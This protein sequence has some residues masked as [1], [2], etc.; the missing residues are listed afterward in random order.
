MTRLFVRWKDA[1]LKDN[2][3]HV[4]PPRPRVVTFE[5]DPGFVVSVFPIYGGYE[6]TIQKEQD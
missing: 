5:S 6:V 2:E 3:H 1:T 4:G